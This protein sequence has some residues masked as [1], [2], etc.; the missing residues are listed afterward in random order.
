M[1]QTSQPPVGTQ[2]YCTDKP[3]VIFEI[4]NCIQSGYCCVSLTKNGARRSPN[5]NTLKFI[6]FDFWVKATKFGF[7]RVL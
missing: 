2:F 5:R 3:E 7:I 6:E 1:T 4:Y